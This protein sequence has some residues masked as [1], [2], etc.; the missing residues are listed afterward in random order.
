MIHRL[1][2]KYSWFSAY[3]MFL[4]F[5]SSLVPAYGRGNYVSTARSFYS[6]RQILANRNSIAGHRVRA[7]DLRMAGS[8]AKENVNALPPPTPADKMDIG[9]PS[10]PEMSS[11][12]S[13]G[14]NN[15]VNLFTGD[16]SYNIPLLDVG[17]YPV[18]IFY[19]GS[20]SME[21]EASW[22]GLGWNINPGTVNRNMRG[23]P[24]DFNGEDTLLQTQRMKDNN[25]F[26]VNVG[27]NIELLGIDQLEMF[28]GSAGV[29]LG[30]SF[31]NYLGP[32][33]DLGL[34]GSTGLKVAS[35]AMG[36]KNG[37]GLKLSG[38][39]DANLSSRYGLTVSPN[40]SLT[41]AAEKSHNGVSTGL[42]LSTSYNSRTGIK[43]LQLSE[44]VSYNF[45]S[46]RGEHDDAQGGASILSTSITFAKPSYIPS[47]RLPVTNSAFSGHF[48]LGVGLF[49]GYGS[50][51]AEVYKQKAEI[52]SADT[53]QRKQMVGYLYYQKATAN[54]NAVMDFARFNDKEV[55]PNTPIIS[56]PQ[57]SYDVFSIQ[58]E[59]TGGSIRA[60]RNDLGQVRDNLTRSKDKNVSLG[61]DVGPPGHFGANFNTIKTPSSIGGWK[62][63]NKLTG[64]MD[65]REAR[66]T[67]ENVYLRNPGETSVL[68]AAQ[69]DRIGGTDLVRFALGGSDEDPTIEPVLEKFSKT[70]EKLG[71]VSVLT[72]D[73]PERKK[74]TQ[75]TSFLTAEEASMAGL[76]KKIRS[77]DVDSVLDFRNNLKFSEM[78]RISNIRKPHHLSQ[79][80]V[81]ESDGK[82]YIYGIPVYNIK[83]QD[84]T[85]TVT[86]T[87]DPTTPDQVK[88]TEGQE[89]SLNKDKSRDG[90]K[91]ITQTPGYAHS[92]LLSGLLSPDYVDVNRDGITE[93]DQGTAV[94]FNYTKYDDHSWRTPLTKG[95]D[96]TANFNA[97]TLSE[98]KDDKGVISYGKRESWYLHSIESKTMIALFTLENRKDGSGPS[99]ETHGINTSDHSLKRLKKIDLYSK[100]DLKK[101]GLA[102]ARPIKTVWFAYSYLLC[103]NSPDNNEETETLNGVNVNE[104]KGKL[105]LDSIYFTFNGKTRAS[106]NK[107]A[108]SYGSGGD[109]PGYE[110]N[111]S[112]RWGNFKQKTL[113]PGGIRNSYYPYSIQDASQKA[114]IDQ[115]AA[116]WSLKKILLP[117]GGQLEVDYESDDYAYVQNKQATEMMQIAGLG[118]N[119]SAMTN[120]LYTISGLGINDNDYIFIKVPEP[121]ANKAEVLEKYL[122]GINQLAFKVWVN[123]PKSGEYVQSYADIS[124]YGRYDDDHIW[125]KMTRTDNLSPLSL[126]ALEYLR[127]QLPGQAFD[128]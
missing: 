68:S 120:S 127:E 83:Q 20:I 89:K 74:R 111:A 57:Y 9:G 45:K 37:S 75:V 98:T 77:Y 50:I 109:N 35:K 67:Q 119:A 94:K 112:D 104:A 47:I 31:N 55:T 17:G 26:G 41:A 124:D 96:P 108:F 113:N 29:S 13:V 62:N 121:C 85:F 34:K 38:G 33:M 106:K 61:A 16:F 51:E 28:K 128:G 87:E 71:N 82:R 6:T 73:P 23:I 118:K 63:G 60:Y 39:L 58:G 95:S 21:Q 99:T 22:V 4:I 56:A 103:A 79:I 72:E 44:Q 114:T 8:P 18:N 53:L 7:K 12:K 59:G 123:M 100:A 107:Y 30:I 15:M 126:A 97:G 70:N 54:P 66:D 25:T 125:I 11:F 52:A 90:F 81:T 19:D 14:T 92:F 40:V 65:F 88:F 110:F 3:F 86:N 27:A 10:Q 84:F 64:V 78:S 117:S 5:L 116:A 115:N 48:Q 122:K 42:S 76:D 69:F 102:N 101:N 80:N 46:E 105:T 24:D 1:S 49:G 36:E 93:D 32:A 2:V 91:Q 43:A